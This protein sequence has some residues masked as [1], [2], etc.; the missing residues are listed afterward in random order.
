MIIFMI[1]YGNSISTIFDPS[2]YVKNRCINTVKFEEKCLECQITAD[3]PSFVD[4]TAIRS[5]NG[6]R[7]GMLY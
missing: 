4:S 6:P 1:V 3:T 7:E 5:G 2:F